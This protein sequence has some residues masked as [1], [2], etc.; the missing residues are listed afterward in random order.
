ME[1]VYVIISIIIV[2]LLV[3]A[4]I[5][6]SFIRLNLRCENA[7]ASIDNQLK[8][9]YDLIPNLVSVVKGYMSHEKEVLT[10][11]IEARNGLV[12]KDLDEKG[13]AAFESR[14]AVSKLFA[15]AESYP[16]LKANENFIKLQVE[17][18]G[19]EDKVA[20]ARQYYNDSVMMFNNKV[21]SFPSNL[22]ANIF[23]FSK[24]EFFEIEAAAR[25]NVEVNL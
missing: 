15:L 12:S 2:L 4:F 3:L 5:Y 22:I 16:E 19:T 6:N 24:K 23:S 13:E 9:R 21:Q 14:Q 1:I 25:D 8:R 11:V 20:Y 10:A 7:V 18:V 17:L